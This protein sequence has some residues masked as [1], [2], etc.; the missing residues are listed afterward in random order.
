[1]SGKILDALS[2]TL[3]KNPPQYPDEWNCFMTDL[4]MKPKSAARDQVEKKAKAKTYHD[5]ES[6]LATP[7]MQLAKDLA[8]AG[9]DEMVKKTYEGDYD[10]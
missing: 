1:M 5:F 7:K 8:A 6:S 9:Y 3:E 10:F 2:K 4:M